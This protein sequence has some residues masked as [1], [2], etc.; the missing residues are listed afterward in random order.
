[1]RMNP[2]RKWLQANILHSLPN[3]SE[4]ELDNE[5]D[6]G[7]PKK[8]INLTVINRNPDNEIFNE[9]FTI[10]EDNTSMNYIT[11]DSV[12]HRSSVSITPLEKIKAQHEFI[13]DYNNPPKQITKY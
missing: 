13:Y 10:N 2:P 12:H 11:K 9:S 4:Y 8:K 5:N 3:K 1:M 6:K 7:V